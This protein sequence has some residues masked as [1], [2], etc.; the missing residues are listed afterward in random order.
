[1]YICCGPDNILNYPPPPF[2]PMLMDCRCRGLKLDRAT[3]Q[4]PEVRRNHNYHS[5]I[6]WPQY[7]HF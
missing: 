1:M 6:I 7:E 5:F 2:P 3:K 4:E